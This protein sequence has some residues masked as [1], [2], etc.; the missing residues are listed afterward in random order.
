M[1]PANKSIQLLTEDWDS[2]SIGVVHLPLQGQAISITLEATTTN[3]NPRG[4][5]VSQNRIAMR[6]A[7]VRACVQVSAISNNLLSE[8]RLP[9]RPIEKHIYVT[10][11]YVGFVGDAVDCPSPR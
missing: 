9:E 3:L 8:N 4:S 2:V 11:N 6:A 7:Q 10:L 1:C 5:Q